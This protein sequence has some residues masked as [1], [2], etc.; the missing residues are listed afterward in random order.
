MDTIRSIVNVIENYLELK[1]LR[2]AGSGITTFTA[3]T[4]C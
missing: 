3:I 2:L 4:I 1:N